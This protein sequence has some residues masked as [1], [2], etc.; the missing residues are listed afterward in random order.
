M[1]LPPGVGYKVGAGTKITHLVLQVPLPNLPLSPLV[2]FP[3][4]SCPTTHAAAD[5]VCSWY[6]TCDKE[7]MYQE[8]ACKLLSNF[9]WKIWRPEA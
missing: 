8:Q 5:P 1:H 6:G 7:G 9:V 4:K 2:L 3:I